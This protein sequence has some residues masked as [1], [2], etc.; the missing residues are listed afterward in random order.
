M[1]TLDSLS[2]EFEHIW[3]FFLPDGDHFIYMGRAVRDQES[4]VFLGSLSGGSRTQVLSSVANVMYSP[5]GYLLFLKEQALLAQR[6]DVD[7]GSLTGDPV[8]VSDNVGHIPLLGIAAFSVS[9][10]GVVATGGGRSVNRQLTWFDRNGTVLGVVSKPGN[11]FD[12]ALSPDE[13]KVAVQLWD[14]L[15]GNSDIWILDPGRN[16]SSR[17]T[18]GASVE[19]DPVW[20]PD[21]KWVL[22]SSSKEGTPNLYRKLATGTGS[23][24]LVL[25]SPLPLYSNDW[26]PDGKS[27]IFN[28][29]NPG[30]GFDIWAVPAEGKSESY[31]LVETEFDEWLARISPDGKFMAYASNE[32][33][34]FEVY[35]RG[36]SGTAE[37]SASGKWQISPN[38]GS[39]PVWRRDGR[40]LYYISPGKTLMAVPVNAGEMF[41]YGT[42]QPLFEAAVDNFDAPRRF[43]V[44]GNGTKFLVNTPVGESVANPVT[45][46]INW[47]PESK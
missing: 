17:L 15:G 34:R 10:N 5:P 45:I 33:G 46:T 38:G 6:I 12:L 36:Y 16:L 13:S 23:E 19:D 30:K 27:I 25:A 28:R 4:G 22:F 1:T 3:P 31:P 11:Y 24:E 39:Q 26:S 37:S 32:S 20:S 14:L 8:L 47:I 35:V 42:P 41:E 29:Q 7:A 43:V 21:G 18:F 40:E 9:G 44:T 2:G